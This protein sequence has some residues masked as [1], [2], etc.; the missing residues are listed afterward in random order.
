MA[1]KEERKKR[2]RKMDKKHRTAS[3]N[4]SGPGVMSETGSL[5]RRCS[6][7]IIRFPGSNIIPAP[8]YIQ[9]P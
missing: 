8:L 6:L 3:L 9:S 5:I 1:T 2:V 7:E 4:K